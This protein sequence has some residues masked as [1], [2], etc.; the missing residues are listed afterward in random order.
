[1][2]YDLNRVKK[3]YDRNSLPGYIFFWGHTPKENSIDKSCF[4]QWYPS[5]FIHEDITYATAEHWMMAK[6][7]ALFNDSGQLALVL[8][9]PDPAAAKKAGRAVSNFEASKWEKHAFQLVVEGNFHKFSQ[10]NDLKTFLLNTGEKI[11]VEASPYDT[12]W[13]IGL[14]TYENN[15]H[16]WKGTN[17]LGF[18][19]MEVRDL[20]KTRL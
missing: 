14:Q 7:A 20:L 12:I 1:M 2:K 9:N 3:L 15:P 6:K 18:A 16:Q 10:N 8:S 17:L 4:S 5:P 19:L 13:G 11:L